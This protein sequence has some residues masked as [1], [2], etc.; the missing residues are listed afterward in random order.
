[1]VTKKK[2][3]ATNMS[4]G[5]KAANKP[6]RFG[7]V[8]MKPIGNAKLNKK[9]IP[10]GKKPH[11]KMQSHASFKKVSNSVRKTMGY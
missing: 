9:V 2:G 7:S 1:M 3:S 8:A 4:A 6:H 5:Q 11:K 10:G